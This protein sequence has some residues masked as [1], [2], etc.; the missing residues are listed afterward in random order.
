[1]CTQYDNYIHQL[2]EPND[3]LIVGKQK[4][5]DKATIFEKWAMMDEDRDK[6]HEEFYRREREYQESIKNYE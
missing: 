4:R 6:D 3:R 5:E 1:M 2:I